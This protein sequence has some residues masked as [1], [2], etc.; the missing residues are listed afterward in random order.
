MSTRARLNDSLAELESSIS[1]HSSSTYE[2]YINGAQV[3]FLARLRADNCPG[4]SLTDFEI[5]GYIGRGGYG[6]VYRA[7]TKDAEVCALKVQL[8]SA[9]SLREKTLSYAFDSPFI[10]RALFAFQDAQLLY[11]ASEFADYG[12]LKTHSMAIRDFGSDELVRLI[13]AQVVLAFEYMHSCNHAH[14]DL[15]LDNVLLFKNGY[16]KLCDLGVTQSVFDESYVFEGDDEH[17]PPDKLNEKL[18]RISPEWSGLGTF[19]NILIPRG[20]SQITYPRP[21][22]GTDCVDLLNQ[23]A[24]R[25]PSRRIGFATQ[26]KNHAWF[27]SVDF[28]KL[29]Y[30][31]IPMVDKLP[32]GLEHP[33]IRPTNAVDLTDLSE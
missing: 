16:I 11:V 28:V 32:P 27:R 29:F 33:Q 9:Q 7:R 15:K 4:A 5:T 31:T 21:T 24:N 19:I 12:D 10:V 23:L 17:L 26:V 8:V 1:H 14:G 13:A 3:D 18:C 6:R 22:F 2:I 20:E 25:D 30:Q